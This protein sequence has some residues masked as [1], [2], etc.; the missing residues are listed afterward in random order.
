M[1]AEAPLKD[2]SDNA[3]TEPAA[4]PFKLMEIFSFGAK[5]L[6][7]KFTLL[8]GA[9]YHTLGVTW[10]ENG[11]M[12]MVVN[13]LAALLSPVA[14][15]FSVPLLPNGIVIGVDEAAPEASTVVCAA[16]EPA[17]RLTPSPGANPLRVILTVE[18]GSA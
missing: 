4:E 17:A 10:A 7:L 15:T 2:P 11:A 6:P 18:P 5:P 1:V 16:A 9:V 13:P 12:V 14:V 3:V 8:P